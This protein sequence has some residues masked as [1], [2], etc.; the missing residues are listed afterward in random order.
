VRQRRPE[1]GGDEDDADAERSQHDWALFYR[2]DV[3]FLR[4]F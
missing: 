1:G 4:H 3:F 2:S